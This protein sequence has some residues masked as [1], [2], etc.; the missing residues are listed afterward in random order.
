MRNCACKKSCWILSL[1]WLLCVFKV[2]AQTVT[3]PS[4]GS[5]SITTCSAPVCDTGG[6]YGEYYNYCDGY[7]VIQAATQGALFHITGT[8]DTENNW[9]YLYIYDG[10]GTNGTLLYRFTGSGS[11]DFVSISDVVTV[12]FTSDV[13]NTDDGFVLQV[14]CCR[15]GCIAPSGLDVHSVNGST[16]VTWDYNSNIQS[17]LL[18]Y[19]PSGFAP[20]TGTRVLVNDTS[21]T[22]NGLT[23]GSVYDFCLYF[24]CDNDGFV[25]S[26]PSVCTTFWVPVMVPESGRETLTT[27]DAG[28]FG[29]GGGGGFAGELYG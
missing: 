1:L 19:G 15:C 7:L 2:D 11:V 13:S 24:D 22:V 26:D 27:C 18:E 25:T 17:Y 8:Y 9:D 16:M 21:Y 5:Q 6:I 12:R 10:A 14:E 23:N 4:S 20:G 28:L 3:V 29:S